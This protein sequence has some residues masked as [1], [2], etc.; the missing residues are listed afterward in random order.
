MQRLTVKHIV[1]LI[2]IVVLAALLVQKS[3]FVKYPGDYP[4]ILPPVKHRVEFSRDLITINIQEP[5]DTSM[6]VVYAYEDPETLL[7]II[8]NVYENNVSLRPGDF[9]DYAVSVKNH[10]ITGHR[11]LKISGRYTEKKDMFGLFSSAQDEGRFYGVQRCLYPVC[12]TCIEECDLV[13]GS[14][15]IAL[16]MFTGERGEIHPVLYRGKCPRCGHCY[17]KCPMKEIVKSHTMGK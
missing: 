16:E 10:R 14:G 13:T 6:I 7:C 12:R 3:G 8:K 9:A 15:E 2:I 5:Y 4:K 11:M 17:V 1:L